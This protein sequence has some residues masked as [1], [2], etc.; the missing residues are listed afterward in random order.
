MAVLTAGVIGCVLVVLMV[1]RH[2]PVGLDAMAACFELMTTTEPTPP[3]E[4]T[5]HHV[6]PQFGK[7]DRLLHSQI[8]EHPEVIRAIASWIRRRIESSA[9]V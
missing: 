2:A 7:S 5:V 6:T 3:H 1:L 4:A 9:T 8:Y